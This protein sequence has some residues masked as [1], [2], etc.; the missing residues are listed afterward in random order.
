MTDTF[1]HAREPLPCPYCSDHHL[2]DLAACTKS[3]QTILLDGKYRLKQLLGEG[4][5]GLVWD[6]RNIDTQK[7][8]AIKSL[9][10]EVVSN[11]AVLARFL[12]EATAAGRIHNP[13]VCDVL[14]LVKSSVHGPYIV[15]ERL[16]GR[17][18]EALI[19]QQGRL[20]PETAV[21]L[22]RQ[23]L[24]GLEAVHRA[25]I[26]HRD[27]KPENIFLHEP[28]DGHLVVKLLDFGISKFS[29]EGRKA[30]TAMNLFMGT[31]AYTSPE[32]ARGAA[33]VDLRTDI[34]AIGAILYKALSGVGPFDGPDL[35]SMLTAILH[36]P[37]PPLAQVAPQVPEGLAAVVDRCLRKDREQR[38]A[39]CAELSAAL[40]PFEGLAFARTA[41]ASPQGPSP[42]EPSGAREH[43]ELTPTRTAVPRPWA[44]AAGPVVR[45]A[46][47]VIDEA[48]DPQPAP[49]QAAA[50][51]VIIG[52]NPADR[53]WVVHLQQHLKTHRDGN[54]LTTC[55]CGEFEP[56]AHQRDAIATALTG[57]KAVILL[58]SPQFLA[59]QFAPGEELYSLAFM[60]HGRG[61]PVL[62]LM[63]RDSDYVD[64]DLG[65]FKVLGNPARPL[66]SL[67]FTEAD[68]ALE[69]ICDQ[70][71]ETLDRPALGGPATAQA[72]AV[73]ARAATILKSDS[74][75]DIEHRLE[76]ARARKAQLEHLGE[77]TRT[78]REEINMLCRSLRMG[79]SLHH[80]DV[81][82]DRF[83]VLD[84]LGAGGFATVWRAIDKST[85]SAVAL[86][87][88]HSQ[89][90][91]NPERRERFFRGARIMAQLDHP[92]IVKIIEPWASDGE[93]EYFAMQYVAGGTLRDAVMGGQLSVSRRLQMLLA[94]AD[95]L[96]FAHERGIV[97][98]D[99]KP[100]NILVAE[101]GT[102]YLTDFDLVRANDTTGG[103]A[104]GLGTV[105]YAA[106]EMMEQAGEA[107]AR[108][109]VYGL[110]MTLAFLFYERDLTMDVIR[111]TDR[112]IGELK[113]PEAIRMVIRTAITWNRDHRFRTGAEFRSALFAAIKGRDSLP[114][115]LMA[116]PRP[117]V[118][119]STVLAA[120]AS[121]APP[122]GRPSSPPA[123]P[124]G[125]AATTIAGSP[126]LAAPTIAPT[127]DTPADN[128]LRT[129]IAVV[130]P[131]ASQPRPA[132][133]KAPSS[134]DD[135][136][137]TVSLVKAFAAISKE[138]DVLGDH[139][140]AAVFDSL[141]VHDLESSARRDAAE[142]RSPVPLPEDDQTF[143]D[144]ARRPSAGTVA[145]LALGAGIVG[146][147]IYLMFAG[148]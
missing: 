129:E 133:T 54:R 32:Q 95:A 63:V 44:D 26:V 35:P 21:Q 73:P 37:H 79:R 134:A 98:R 74:T 67:A 141:E 22:L 116:T 30:M 69:E 120:T 50:E 71:V 140:V 122:A 12:W 72:T 139:A 14:D 97:H 41:F 83:V 66:D 104:G 143:L 76:L 131:M 78:V 15:L 47:L 138:S 101:D 103:T 112:L 1:A 10:A 105:I 96:A 40:A 121:P 25:G 85:D 38:Y 145:F 7:E 55:D 87:V 75:R 29:V 86:K 84:L 49:V 70:I 57:A 110:G 137:P 80:G 117:S 24:I 60:A 4:S 48:E 127:P 53:R 19:Q 61:L 51:H 82:D 36:T 100:S 68:H 118:H 136:Q 94:V 93:Y 3:G 5:F 144:T 148:S 130:V 28:G 23:A 113:V 128:G 111:D 114:P 99:V 142:V 34:W 13:H 102:P 31:P 107:D 39:S 43:P 58:V 90:V 33:Q 115:T 17:P 59:E 27:I 106:P 42:P 8:V 91:H 147:L 2:E 64:T 56:G 89:H 123:S 18:L 109:D 135:H 92:H 125:V 9:R 6:A 119:S 45:D 20:T 46:S 124:P 62:W 126:P 11:P 52:C 16:F 146:T 77:D 108:A 132:D 65:D 81:L 88:L